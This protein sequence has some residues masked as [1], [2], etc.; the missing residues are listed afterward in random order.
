MPIDYSFDPEAR[1]ILTRVT[2]A[3]TIA[4]TEDY[5]KRLG[6]DGGCPAEAIEVVDFSGVSDFAIQFGEMRK[7]T[8]MYQTT[9]RTRRILAT[10]FHCNSDLSYGIARMLKTLHQIANEEHPVT[11]TR[12]E[13]ER[14]RCIEALRSTADPGGGSRRPVN[15]VSLEG[16]T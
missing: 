14:D 11:V 16:Q 15:P 1:L 6:L 12:S 10:V 7:I 9:K 2:G 3:L 8:E 5:F 4:L 13:E